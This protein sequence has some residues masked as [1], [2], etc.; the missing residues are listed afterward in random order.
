MF[1]F[2][3]DAAAMVMLAFDPKRFARFIQSWWLAWLAVLAFYVPIAILC[4]I[5]AFGRYVWSKARARLA[6]QEAPK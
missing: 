1:K 6:R 5:V 4:A 3:S 2:A